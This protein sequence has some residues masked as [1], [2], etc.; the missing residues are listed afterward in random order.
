MQKNITF[1]LPCL[2]VEYRAKR[3]PAQRYTHTPFPQLIT[4][5]ISKFRP[6]GE[7]ALCKRRFILKYQLK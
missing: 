2:A 3:Q 4:M 1:Y 7:T 6:C 5:F